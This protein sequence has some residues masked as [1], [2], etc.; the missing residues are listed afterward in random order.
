MK[1][2]LSLTKAPVQST[3]PLFQEGVFRFQFPIAPV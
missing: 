1:A 3:P 2:Y